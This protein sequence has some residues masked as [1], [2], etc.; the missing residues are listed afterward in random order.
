MPRFAFQQESVYRDFERIVGVPAGIDSLRPAAAKRLVRKCCKFRIV[1][2]LPRSKPCNQQVDER[3]HPFNRFGAQCVF[4]HSVFLAW[5]VSEGW[6]ES[7]K[8]PRSVGMEGGR[9]SSERRRSQL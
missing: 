4:T 7:G 1:E 2:A 6:A 5:G 9:R 8:L 3:A